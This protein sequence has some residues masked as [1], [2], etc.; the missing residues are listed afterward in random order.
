MQTAIPRPL[1]SV[2]VYV[3]GDGTQAL[4]HAKQA[5]NHWAMPALA[6]LSLFLSFVL[7]NL[8][9]KISSSLGWP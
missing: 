7:S 8:F 4:V 1:L 3:T 5:P 2:S 6:F 9:I